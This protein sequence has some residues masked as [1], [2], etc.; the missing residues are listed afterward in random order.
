M[1]YTGGN[2]TA[3][4]VWSLMLAGAAHHLDLRAPDPADPPSVGRARAFMTTFVAD[5]V[6]G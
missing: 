4:N 2:N 5:L 1:G 3:A 6:S